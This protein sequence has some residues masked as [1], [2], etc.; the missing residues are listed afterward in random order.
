MLQMA[1]A[2]AYRHIRF[3]DEWPHMRLSPRPLFGQGLSWLGTELHCT[4]GLRNEHRLTWHA[5]PWH[6]QEAAA[7][8]PSLAQRCKTLHCVCALPIC[9]VFI[10]LDRAKLRVQ[11][12]WAWFRAQQQRSGTDGALAL[13]TAAFFC[14]INCALGVRRNRFPNVRRQSRLPIAQQTNRPRRCLPSAHDRQQ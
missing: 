13:P 11:H 6:C 7:A 8:L 3:L 10:R 4:C 1:E 5:M 14:K 12:G 9:P 2:N